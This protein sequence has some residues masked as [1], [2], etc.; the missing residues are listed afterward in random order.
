MYVL[1][2]NTNLPGHVHTLSCLCELT[3]GNYRQVAIFVAI[4]T[5]CL[6]GVGEG[7]TTAA[8]IVSRMKLTGVFTLVIVVNKSLYV[9]EKSLFFFVGGGI[10]TLREECS[11]DSMHF[12]MD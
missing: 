1:R 7:E 3:I 9:C 10:V 11:I 4:G 2:T 6:G 5:R 8:I 12:E